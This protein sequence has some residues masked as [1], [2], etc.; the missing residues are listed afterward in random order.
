MIPVTY[1]YNCP[2]GYNHTQQETVQCNTYT[3][4][5]INSVVLCHDCKKRLRPMVQVTYA[6]LQDTAE[7]TE[8]I[9]EQLSALFKQWQQETTVE[10]Q[11]ETLQA[12]IDAGILPSEVLAIEEQQ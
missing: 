8:S 5:L 4:L 6:P 11:R 12:L 1:N 2:C 3:R 7:P 10:E 9:A